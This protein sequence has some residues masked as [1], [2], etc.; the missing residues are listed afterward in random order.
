MT[1]PGGLGSSFQVFLLS[2]EERMAAKML[3]EAREETNAS[4]L[5]TCLEHPAL[6]PFM[7]AFTQPYRLYMCLLGSVTS[8]RR[9]KLPS[10]S[11]GDG[12][13]RLQQRV[14]TMS[15]NPSLCN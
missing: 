2:R 1:K 13:S 11:S 10:P 14:S 6:F 7:R 3:T 8:I 4:P 5:H 9:S 15:K 12:I